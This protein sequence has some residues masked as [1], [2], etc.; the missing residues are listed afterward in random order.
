MNLLS[1]INANGAAAD[2]GLCWFVFGFRPN[3]SSTST[4]PITI[5][6]NGTTTTLDF[7][8]KIGTNDNPNVEFIDC[9]GTYLF[10]YGCDPA[11]PP[12]APCPCPSGECG[13]LSTYEFD[14]NGCCGGTCT[15]GASITYN[16]STCE[17]TYQSSGD[18]ASGSWELQYSST[19]A[20]PWSVV[21]SGSGNIAPTT[22]SP[23]NN[24]FYRIKYNAFGDCSDIFSNVVNVSCVVVPSCTCSATLALN[25]CILDVDVFGADCPGRPWQ[26]QYSQ[27]GTGW[28]N[29]A[30]GTGTVSTTHTPANNGLYRLVVTDPTGTCT[31]IQTAN[32]DVQCVGDN[33]CDGW[34]LSSSGGATEVFDFAGMNQSQVLYWKFEARNVPD[35]LIIKFNGVTLLDTGY[36]SNHTSCSNATNDHATVISCVN[37]A[38]GNLLGDLYPAT[39]DISISIPTGSAEA[40]ITNYAGT[41]SSGSPNPHDYAGTDTFVFGAIPI[42]AGLAGDDIEVTVNADLCGIGSTFWSLELRCS[43]PF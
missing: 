42:T 15:C 31:P 26:L 9:D 8:D 20:S 12:F 43:A 21:S 35:Q 1:Q 2:P 6:V 39:G 34:I 41:C 40:R 27:S 22:V 7:G 5:I 29:V 32:V 25:G 19:G 4:T 17:I 28:Q 30:S 16:Q 24:G 33:L 13:D 38:G 10:L 14:A 11:T 37:A 18:C 3:G 23:A 36:I